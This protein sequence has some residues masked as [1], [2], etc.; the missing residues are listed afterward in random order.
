MIR[1]RV[2]VVNMR[3]GAGRPRKAD[4]G[5]NLERIIEAAWAI[6]DA[7][8]VA[9]LSTRALAKLLNVQSPALYWHVKSKDELLSVMM[10]RLLE[11]S[12][13]ESS[14]KM[15]WQDWLRHVGRRQRRSLLSH[16][17][18]GIIASIARPSMKL[19]KDLFPKLFQPLRDAGVPA[20]QASSAAGALASLVIGWVLYEQR[21]E[22]RQFVEAYHSSDDG[23]EFALEA[24]IA[25]IDS[26][27]ASETT[28]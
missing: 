26:K 8:G 5:I 19:Q 10:E 21:P 25:G 23:F 15:G 11:D 4:G 18:T 24:L 27:V 7:E 9:K 14:E 2:V 13:A 12:L 28:K 17:D 1:R 22:T 3:S 20:T 16:R 6:V